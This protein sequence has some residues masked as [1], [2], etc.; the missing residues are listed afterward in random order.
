MA[1]KITPKKTTSTKVAGQASN[2]LKSK[3]TGKDSKTSAGSALSQT[4]DSKKVTSKRAA[5]IASKVLKDGR[6]SSSS[7]SAA[8]STLSQAEGKGKINIKGTGPRDK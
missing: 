1:K 7:K 6:T 3:S 2:V 5:T 4:K 8:G